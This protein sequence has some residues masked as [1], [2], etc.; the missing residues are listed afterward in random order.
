MQKNDS[1]ST[2]KKAYVKQANINL[3]GQAISEK[4]RHNRDAKSESES[5]K[6]PMGQFLS[7][8]SEF[9]E[10]MVIERFSMQL[11]SQSQ[12]SIFG[13]IDKQKNFKKKSDK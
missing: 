13:G 11:H 4:G 9:E 12:N 7:A 5:M 3:I 1:Q 10:N 8:S 6:F 2:N